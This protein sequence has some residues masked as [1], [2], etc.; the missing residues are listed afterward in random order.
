MSIKVNNSRILHRNFKDLSA[1]L[2]DYFNFYCD[3]YEIPKIKSNIPISDSH[4]FAYCKDRRHFV[5][6]I[7]FTS[8]KEFLLNELFF[9]NKVQ[10]LPIAGSIRIDLQENFSDAAIRMCKSVYP[11]ILL[12]ELEPIAI[13]ENEFSFG[14]KHCNHVGIAF[15]TRIRNIKVYEELHINRS[16]RAQLINYTNIDTLNSEDVL[17]SQYDK[18]M[19]IAKEYIENWNPYFTQEDEIEGYT[20]KKRRFKFHNNVTKPALNAFSVFFKESSRSMNIRIEEIIMQ[21]KPK[22]VIDIACGDNPYVINV[23][24]KNEIEH[25]VVNDMS[26]HQLELLKEKISSEQLENSNS[27]LIFTNH[28]AKKLPFRD[29]TFDVLICKNVLHHMGNFVD[30]S[31]L[32]KEMERISKKM[33][34]IEILN[35]K[36]EGLWG[37]IRHHL[38]YNKLLREIEAGDNF[39]SR[40]AFS[41]ICNIPRNL[42]DKF[43]LKTSKGIY[44]IAIF[45]S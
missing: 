4:S 9:D 8:K 12:G 37:R 19:N 40:E 15:I 24:L 22:N 33:I 36:F 29:K 23:G 35:P 1:E 18:V 20:H 3:S 21:E 14:N 28:D 42:D 39:L 41:Q 10:W 11:N 31:N 27:L 17:A 26:Q 7:P 43:E 38:I 5:L 2:D 30:F 34:I 16:I 13:L 44:Q 45:T 32:I 25:I 6:V